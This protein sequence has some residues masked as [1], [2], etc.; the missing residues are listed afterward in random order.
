MMGDCY[1]ASVRDFLETGFDDPVERP[2]E[3]LD[4]TE[5]SRPDALRIPDLEGE[6]LVVVGEDDPFG[7][8]GKKGDRCGI[9]RT[10]LEFRGAVDRAAIDYDAVGCTRFDEETGLALGQ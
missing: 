8:I 4:M 2:V 7:P 1:R 6:S 5:L 10:D 9:I 3:R